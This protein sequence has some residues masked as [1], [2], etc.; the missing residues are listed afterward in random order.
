MIIVL[1]TSADIWR[2]YKT[3]HYLTT[4]KSGQITLNIHWRQQGFN[5]GFGGQFNP[6][7]Y[8]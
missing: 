6:D 2:G 7:K 5:S 1:I 4:S 8:D 3:Q